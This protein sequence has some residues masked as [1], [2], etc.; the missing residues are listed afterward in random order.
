VTTSTAWAL[1]DI[2]LGSMGYINIVMVALL[3]PVAIKILKD[4]KEQRKAGLDPVFKP[5]N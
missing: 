4:Y 1:G 2:G 3:A 5:L